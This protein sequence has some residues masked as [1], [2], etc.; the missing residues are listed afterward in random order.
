MLNPDYILI[1]RNRTLNKKAGC[2]ETFFIRR[3]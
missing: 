2:R 1:K 3:Q